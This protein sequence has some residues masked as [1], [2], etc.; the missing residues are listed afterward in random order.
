MKDLLDDYTCSEST[1][2][3]QKDLLLAEKGWFKFAPIYGVG[4]STALNDED[5]GDLL[6]KIRTEFQRDKMTILEIIIKEGKIHVNA[7]Y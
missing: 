1:E 7:H 3:H 2:S 5:F 4:L 6:Q